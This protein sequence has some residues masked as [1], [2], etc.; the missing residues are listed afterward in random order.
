[1]EAPKSQGSLCAEGGVGGVQGRPEGTL[2]LEES[3]VEQLEKHER[4][5]KVIFRR[6]R[7]AAT[8]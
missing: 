2:G 6:R 3:R 8:R 1:M 7:S 4:S 5:R